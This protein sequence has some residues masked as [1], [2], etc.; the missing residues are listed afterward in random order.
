MKHFRTYEIYVA[1]ERLV[2]RR[3]FSG[4][5]KRLPDFY[6]MGHLSAASELH[7]VNRYW[8][9]GVSREYPSLLDRNGRPLAK[10]PLRKRQLKAREV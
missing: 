2:R 3:I 1:T 6:V 9:G 10:S 8:N 7:A 5:E 4:G